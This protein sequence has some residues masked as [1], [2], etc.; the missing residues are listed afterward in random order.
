MPFQESLSQNHNLLSFPL[1]H[2]W[3]APHIV[4]ILKARYVQTNT[5]RSIAPLF[6]LNTAL[7]LHVPVGKHY[8]N[9]HCPPNIGSMHYR[10]KYATDFNLNTVKQGREDAQY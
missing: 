4:P 8:C 10:D 3:V 1:R 2:P 7:Y 5:C 6:T 9:T